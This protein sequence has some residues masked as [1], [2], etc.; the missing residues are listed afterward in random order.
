M[1]DDTEVVA[2]ARE[3]NPD[4]WRKLHT[5]HHAAVR[6]VCRGFG[7]LNEADIEDLVQ[8][9]FLKAYDAIDDLRDD[10]RLRPW[11]LSIAR[12]RALDRLARRNR[13]RDLARAFLEDPARGRD[14]PRT[15]PEQSER[16]ARIQI[17]R[18][19]LDSLDD[20]PEAETVRLFYLE[21]ELSAR[22]IAERLGVGKSTVTM[23]LERFRRKVARRLSAQLER[24]ELI[25]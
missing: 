13:Q 3:K 4:A 15:D 16:Q 23:R 20:G 11:L 12:S 1:T 7:G 2:L 14:A 24:E 21:G 8:D 10:R 6:R 17:V 9:T 19:L 5:R 22:Q 25:P 18:E